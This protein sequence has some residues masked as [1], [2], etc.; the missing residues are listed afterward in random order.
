M[1]YFHS[2]RLP[3]M[4]TH[5]AVYLKVHL[6]EVVHF[7]YLQQQY[8]N[9]QNSFVQVKIYLSHLILR[10]DSNG[11]HFLSQKKSPQRLFACKTPY[12]HIYG[13]LFYLYLHYTQNDFA[14][15]LS[16]CLF[17]KAPAVLHP[18]DTST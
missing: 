7:P 1:H 9:R 11:H 15:C 12:H 2:D 16:Y 5:Q 6:H 18:P 10:F 4:T 14:D 3:E 17:R 13:L 8:S